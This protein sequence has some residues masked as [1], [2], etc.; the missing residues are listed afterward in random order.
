MF[1]DHDDSVH[2]IVRTRSKVETMLEAV[3]DLLAEDAALMLCEAAGRRQYSK[4]GHFKRK[5]PGSHKEEE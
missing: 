2:R 5:L 3:L 4:S 1:V